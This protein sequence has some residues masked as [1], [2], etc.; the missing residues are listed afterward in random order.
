[1]KNNEKNINKKLMI[2][3]KKLIP[4]TPENGVRVKDSDKTPFEE[5]KTLI[6]PIE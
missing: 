6:L 3:Y 2:K 4:R 5:K 1:M